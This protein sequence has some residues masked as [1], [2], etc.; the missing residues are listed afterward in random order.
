MLDAEAPREIAHAPY[1]VAFLRFWR[2]LQIT[3]IPIGVRAGNLH[4][5]IK[6]IS[7]L[8]CIMVQYDAI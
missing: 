2:R 6:I 4:C 5:E 8:K 3:S 1:I 7:I